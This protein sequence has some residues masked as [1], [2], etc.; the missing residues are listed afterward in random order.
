MQGYWEKEPWVYNMKSNNILE[1]IMAFLLAARELSPYYFLKQSLFDIIDLLNK[2]SRKIKDTII[3][4]KYYWKSFVCSSFKWII[5]AVSSLP[6]KLQY[7][8]C[9]YM[10]R[11]FFEPNMWLWMV[12]SIRYSLQSCMA[13]CIVFKNRGWPFL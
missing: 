2:Q 9:Y 8:P 4:F 10:Q 7:S 3:C 11:R 13:S 6:Y 1:Q 12:E 5:K